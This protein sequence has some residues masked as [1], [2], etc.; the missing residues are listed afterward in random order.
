MVRIC[1]ICKPQK[2]HCLGQDGSKRVKN[3]EASGIGLR[4][5]E[6]IQNGSKQVKTGQNN[7]TRVNIGQ[8]K[9]KQVDAS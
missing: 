6:K 9:M 4:N 1:N 5:L 3:G 8:N 7:S 2:V